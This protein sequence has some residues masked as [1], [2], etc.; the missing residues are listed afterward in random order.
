MSKKEKSVN[1]PVEEVLDIEP[2]TTIVEY[3]DSETKDLTVP[4]TYDKKDSEIEDDLEEIRKSAYDAF[5]DQKDK[6]QEVES[7]YS[8]RSAEVAAQFL[9]TALDAIREK[10]IIKQ[11]KDRLRGVAGPKTVTGN[12]AP[13]DRNKLIKDLQE[14]EKEEKKQKAIDVEVT[15]IDEV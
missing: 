13:L 1:H 7:K 3:N 6:S 14:L 10:S 12:N 8:A 5:E 11:A 9:K 15:N 4:I 2:G